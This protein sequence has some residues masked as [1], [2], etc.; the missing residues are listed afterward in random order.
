MEL[1]ETLKTKQ[2]LTRQDIAELLASIGKPGEKREEKV[3]AV[4][5]LSRANFQ[6]IDLAASL[7]SYEEY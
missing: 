7:N 4:K 1:I 3:A 2:N 5:Q 6:Q